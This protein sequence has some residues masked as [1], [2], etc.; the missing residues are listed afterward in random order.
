MEEYISMGASIAAEKKV[1]GILIVG[2]THRMR[3]KVHH[4]E[5]KMEVKVMILDW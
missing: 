2:T 5:R 1:T 3:S 4:S